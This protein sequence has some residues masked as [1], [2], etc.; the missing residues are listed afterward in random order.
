MAT[1]PRSPRSTSPTNSNQAKKVIS[2]S[3]PAR[4]KKDDPSGPVGT[5]RGTKDSPTHTPNSTPAKRKPSS[6][7]MSTVNPKRPET[8][9]Q[10]GKPARSK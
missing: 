6:Q 10:D 3:H 9:S 1:D 8:G 2:G 5:K 7:D 4:S